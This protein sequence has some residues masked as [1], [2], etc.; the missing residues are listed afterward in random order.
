MMF[1]TAFDFWDKEENFLLNTSL[2]I[3]ADDDTFY[4]ATLPTLFRV[5]S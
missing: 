1:L 4:L 5:L 2:H 3:V